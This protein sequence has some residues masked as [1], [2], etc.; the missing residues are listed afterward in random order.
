[1]SRVL[2]AL[3]PRAAAGCTIA[4]GM[5][6]LA[7]WVLD[8]PGLKSVLAQEAALE[9]NT[10]LGILLAGIALLRLEPAR[11][12]RHDVGLMA[13]AVLALGGMLL[14]IGGRRRPQLV[15]NPDAA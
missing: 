5:T 14:A 9:A 11:G 7:G 12:T 2:T 6:A 8:L 13:G 10:A 4:I 15:A 1:M 3:V